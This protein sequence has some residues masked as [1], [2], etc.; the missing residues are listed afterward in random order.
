M[1]N[2]IVEGAEELNCHIEVA[3]CVYC[4]ARYV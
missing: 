3:D 1:L 2:C 4:Y